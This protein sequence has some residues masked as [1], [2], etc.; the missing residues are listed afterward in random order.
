MHATE[1]SRGW[2]RANGLLRGWLIHPALPL[3]L[4]CLSA[5]AYFYQAGA[6]NQN[7]R[8]DLVRALAEQQTSVIDDYYRNTGDLS[9]MGPAGRCLDPDP[10]VGNHAYCDK[11][12]GASWLALPMYEILWLARGGIT[13]DKSF[14]VTASYLCTLFAVALPSALGVAVLFWLLQTLGIGRRAA[15]AFSLAYGLATMTFPFATVLFGHSLA[16]A[17]ALAG[18][19]VIAWLR[20]AP[21][22]AAPAPAEAL[23]ATYLAT[24]GVCLGAAVVVEYPCAIIAAVLFVYA[25]FSVP[26]R[27]LGWLVLGGAGPALALAAYH[28]IVFG[29]PTT[30]PYAFSTQ[31]DRGQ[32]MYMGIGAVDPEALWGILFSGYRGLFFSQPWLL[33]AAPGLAVMAQRPKLRADAAVC[34]VIFV[35][36]IWMNASLVD[37]PSGYGFA[38][39]Y[40][41]PALPFLAVAAAALSLVPVRLPALAAALRIAVLG[42]V[43]WSAFLMLVATSVNLDVPNSIE[44]P[45]G[46][47]LLPRFFT[48][49]LAANEQSVDDD[50]ALA[51]DGH[52]AWNLGQRLFGLQG[53]SSLAPL[54]ALLVAQGL[55]LAA[56]LRRRPAPDSGST[57]PAGRPRRAT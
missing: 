10:A 51:G 36:F 52:G 35:A 24:A 5:Y 20:H 47:Y 53:L 42:L 26:L 17:L 44:E 12:P 56:T 28:W 18:Y 32:G 21:A 3:F 30:L 49:D 11:A 33:L 48:G 7:V 13:P 38:P 27:R 31:S 15:V 6:W 34:A 39:R 37:W 55:W 46:E 2:V 25:A 4:I 14:L 16:A 50:D 40:L 22:L 57:M 1:A 8:F 41:I 45:F 54:A 19:A 43:V 29:S 23:Q 9:C